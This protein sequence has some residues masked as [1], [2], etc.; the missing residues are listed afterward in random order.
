MFVDDAWATAGT[1]N[2]DHRSLFVNAEVNPIAMDWV[3]AKQWQ[4]R[5][6]CNIARESLAWRL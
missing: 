6:P 2:L 4:H 5:S 3:S 1:A